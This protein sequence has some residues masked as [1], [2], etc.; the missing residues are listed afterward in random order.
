MSLPSLLRTPPPPV[1]VEI[2]P[3]RVAAVAVAGRA[4]RPQLGAWAVE[5]LPEGA[6]VPSLTA[7]NLARPAEVAAALARRVGTGWASARGASRSSCP[8]R[9]AKVSLVRFKDAPAQGGGPR[10]TRSS[11]S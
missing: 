5:P 3:R 8:T 10:R 9:A 4:R 6:V 1:A 7:S 2:A 11:S